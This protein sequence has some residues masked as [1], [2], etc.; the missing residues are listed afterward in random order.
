MADVE[1]LALPYIHDLLETGALG[2]DL[3]QYFAASPL[4]VA[5]VVQG[6][7]PPAVSE[8]QHQV[9]TYLTVAERPLLLASPWLHIAPVGLPSLAS[10]AQPVA[11]VLAA[12]ADFAGLDPLTFAVSVPVGAA[13]GLSWPGCAVSAG[14]GEDCGAEDSE[15]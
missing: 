14:L 13:F 11:T 3:S 8:K 15:Q 5:A 7:L 4:L 9:A 1:M 2:P 6:P 10:A 12:L